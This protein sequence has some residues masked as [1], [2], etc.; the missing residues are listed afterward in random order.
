MKIKFIAVETTSKKTKTNKDYIELDVS[1]KNLDFQSKIE[2]KKLNPFGNKDVYDTLKSA[3]NG[4]TFD[5]QRVKNEGGFWDWVAITAIADVGDGTSTVSNAPTK[6]TIAPKSTYETPE[7]RAQRQVLIVRQSAIAQSVAT[8][9]VNAKG[10][11]QVE[12]VLQIA[13]TYYDWVFGNKPIV[14]LEDLPVTDSDDDIP[15]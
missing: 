5:I 3:K 7:E 6:G 9:S 15:C 1:Y 10:K 13:E 12:D 14:K 11:V 8:V 4:D 2:A